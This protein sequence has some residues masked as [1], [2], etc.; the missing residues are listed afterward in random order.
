MRH[1]YS[2]V[3]CQVNLGRDRG[4]AKARVL[5]GTAKSERAAHR[6]LHGLLIAKD[7]H[8]AEH[9]SDA[10]IAMVIE[11]WFEQAW[12]GDDRIADAMPSRHIGGRD[13][14]HTAAK[15]TLVSGGKAGRRHGDRRNHGAGNR[16]FRGFPSAGYLNRY[17]RPPANCRTRE[18]AVVVPLDR[19]DFGSQSLNSPTG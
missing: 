7:E 3:V 6:L 4:T 11:Q 8:R 1:G 5:A 12:F 17:E 18:S 19:V 13:G 15:N 2:S 9:V 14:Q 10:T 16:S